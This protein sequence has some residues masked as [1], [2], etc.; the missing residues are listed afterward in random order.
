MI[1]FE[2]KCTA[3]EETITNAMDIVVCDECKKAVCRDCAE[4]TDEKKRC[5]K[6]HAKASGNYTG[7]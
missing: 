2:A 5:P 7:K 4:I 1:G 3:C 6:C